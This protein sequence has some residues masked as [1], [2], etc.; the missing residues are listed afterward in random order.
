MC[1]IVVFLFLVKA[2]MPK[3]RGNPVHYILWWN[4]VMGDIYLIKP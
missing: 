2:K 3:S 1:L 4:D